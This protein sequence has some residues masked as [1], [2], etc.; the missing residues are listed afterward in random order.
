MKK[1]LI[2]FFVILIA[3]ISVAWLAAS[4]IVPEMLDR[5]FNA[6]LLPEAKENLSVKAK[7]LHSSLL[8]ADLHDDALIWGRDLLKRKDYGQVDLP[9]LREGNVAL[10][11]FSVPTK[12][13]KKRGPRGTRADGLNLITLSAL[14]QIWPPA[15]WFSLNSRALYLA[16]RLHDFAEESVGDFR[17][18]K[19]SGHLEKFLNDRQLNMH[20]TAGVLAIEGLHSLQGNPDNLE[21]HFRAG[22]RILGLVH[23]FDNEIGGSSYGIEKGGLT[24]FGRTIIRRMEVLHMAVDLAHASPLLID[25]VLEI[26]TRPVLVSHTGVQGTCDRSR[27]LSDA[28]IRGIARTGGVIGIGFWSGAVCGVDYGQSIAHAIRYVADL[29]GVEHVALGSDFDGDKLPFDVTGMVYITQA[30]LDQDFEEDDIRM[31]M[32]ENIFRLLREVLPGD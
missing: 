27:N 22:Y 17:I 20:L 1:A 9:R 30:L 15:T 24:E 21:K 11:V 31:I 18:M 4:F 2:I 6:V 13:P 16:G 23:Q 26:V 10:Q 3:I 25:D 12:V 29:V 28:H 32:G 8:I 7:A 19:T 5:K 14:T